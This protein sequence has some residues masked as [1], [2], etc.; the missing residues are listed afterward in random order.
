MAE[1]SS[2]LATTL[3]ALGRPTNINAL[4]DADTITSSLL[5]INVL[6][7]VSSSE[8]VSST[9]NDNSGTWGTGGSP[10]ATGFEDWNNSFTYLDNG[11]SAN[12]TD[13]STTVFD[14]SASWG[15]GGSPSTT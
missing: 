2:I 1:F 13:T 7:A 12:I 10:S 9:V 11:G 6:N 3:D 15:A 14:N 8:S 4:G 5:T